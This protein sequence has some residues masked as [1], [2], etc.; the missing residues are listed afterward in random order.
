MLNIADSRFQEDLLVAA[1]RANKIDAS[2]RI[3]ERYR[4]NTPERLE[5]S[6]AAPRAAGLFS[7]YPFGTD[8]TSEEIA[9]A[10]GL[11]WLKENTAD[12]A[13]RLTTLAQA[14]FRP[15]RA[16]DRGH[17]ER[18]KL[19]APANFDE[20]LKARLVSLALARTR[21]APVPATSRTAA[22]GP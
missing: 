9:L 16:E 10:R 12:K 1:R 17:L 8:L 20:R 22:K 15:M 2:Y 19:G 5:E 21:A 7:E 14:L 6:F 4:N 13:A 11:R 18:M 3:P